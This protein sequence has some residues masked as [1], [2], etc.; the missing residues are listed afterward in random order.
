MNF[1]E[2]NLEKKY[3]YL[4]ENPAVVRLPLYDDLTTRQFLAKISYMKVNKLI[5]LA[6]KY[7]LICDRSFDYSNYGFS[8]KKIYRKNTFI[9]VKIPP[10]LDCRYMTI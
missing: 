4:G 1:R 2:K 10:W 5:E 9:S 6:S 3:F 7:F 8:W